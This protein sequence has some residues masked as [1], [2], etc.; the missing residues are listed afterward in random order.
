M[1]QN[2]DLERLPENLH[3]AL[4]AVNYSLFSFD[5]YGFISQCL[6]RPLYPPS[7]LFIF[8]LFLLRGYLQPSPWCLLLFYK[9][10]VL[11]L[12]GVK[13]CRSVRKPPEKEGDSP[14]RELF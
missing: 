8:H 13:H 14:A 2:Q 5:L 12:N 7:P 4:S 11:L 1:I 6:Y 9:I 10:Q 3:L